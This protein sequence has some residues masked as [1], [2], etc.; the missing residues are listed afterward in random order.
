MLL[1]GGGRPL[2][3][4]CKVYGLQSNVNTLLSGCIGYKV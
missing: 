1:I 3:I 2:K 4:A